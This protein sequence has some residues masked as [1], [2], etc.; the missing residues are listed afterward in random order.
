[1]NAINNETHEHWEICDVLLKRDGTFLP[2]TCYRPH[3]GSGDV[4]CS[5]RISAKFTKNCSKPLVFVVYFRISKHAHR[6]STHRFSLILGL[7]GSY[8]DQHLRCNL[9]LLLPTHI[10]THCIELATRIGAQYASADFLALIRASNR[11]KLSRTSRL[12]QEMS[13]TRF[14]RSL[15]SENCSENKD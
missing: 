4:L 14:S 10:R 2:A 3:Y 9:H 13:K 15:Q 7:T 12:G 1:M 6:L 11:K 8:V 5:R